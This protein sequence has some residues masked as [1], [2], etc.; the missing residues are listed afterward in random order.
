MMELA[1]SFSEAARQGCPAYRVHG[2]WG[3][4]A[5]HYYDHKVRFLFAEVARAA[6][7]QICEVGFNAGLTSLLFLEAA[8]V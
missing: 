8:P 4:F 7:L 1:Q 2:Q 5:Q 3:V 6:P